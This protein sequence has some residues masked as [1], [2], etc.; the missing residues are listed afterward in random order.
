MKHTIQ[1]IRWVVAARSG[2][3]AQ[4]ASG[5]HAV[6]RQPTRGRRAFS[7]I[8]LI[9]VIGIIVIV[10]AMTYPI[11]AGLTRGSRAEA[12]LNSVNTALAAARTLATQAKASLDPPI[13]GARFS[14][15]AVIFTPAGEMRLVESKQDAQDGASPPKYLAESSKHGFAD[16]QIGR[17]SCR[18]RV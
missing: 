5:T 6:M 15:A 18:E 2:R 14:G 10:G 7:L 13:A 12:G 3:C 8:E 16:V 11:L 17:A 4:A 1:S 9:V